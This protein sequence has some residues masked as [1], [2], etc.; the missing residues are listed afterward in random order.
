MYLSLNTQ[1]PVG[2][3]CTRY[4]ELRYPQ[5]TVHCSCCQFGTSTATT[6]TA[7][8]P[9]GGG[10]GAA[11]TTTTATTTTAT[12]TVTTSTVITVTGVCVTL[13][14]LSFYLSLL[15]LPPPSLSLSLLLSPLSSLSYSLLSDLLNVISPLSLSYVLSPLFLTNNSLS[16]LS[17]FLLSLSYPPPPHL[18]PLSL[19]QDA[20]LACFPTPCSTL[21]WPWEPRLTG[22]PEGELIIVNEIHRRF[23][24]LGL[25]INR[26]SKI[27]LY[28]TLV[29]P[30]SR[31]RNEQKTKDHNRTG[32]VFSGIRFYQKIWI[33]RTA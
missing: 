32:P 14:H 16:P 22:L 15:S 3:P 13:L 31:L 10:G 23:D 4:C 33:N 28:R 25:S 1:R 26:Y 29:K 24:Q 7:A 5:F 6:T 21:P 2:F 20:S 19:L 11:T 30:K 8:A 17:P 12:T 9:G 27:R 18:S